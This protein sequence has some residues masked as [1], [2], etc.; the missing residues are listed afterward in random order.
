MVNSKLVYILATV[1]RKRNGW[2]PE[3]KQVSRLIYEA[4]YMGIMLGKG[5]VLCWKQLR[6]KTQLKQANV[7]CE[8]T[9][10]LN[11]EVENFVK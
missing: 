2:E 9:V 4:P 3:A 5:F 10:V 1:N 7:G 11:D 6:T 8:I